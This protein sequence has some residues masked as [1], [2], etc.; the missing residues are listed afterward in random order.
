[1]HVG[2]DEAPATPPDGETAAGPD[3]GSS[4]RPRRVL[5]V[6]DDATV[7]E[8]A[9]RYL[10]R[11]GY[12]T[13]VA[14]DGPSALARAEALRPDLVVLDRMLP[15]MDGTEVLRRLR[16]RM[17][18]AVILL[19]A[20]TAEADRV[21]GLDLGA[22]DYVTKPFSPRELVAR[23]RAVLRRG[24]PAS[25]EL[26]R[27]LRA[28]PLEL[29]LP[30]R[31]LWVRGAEAPTTAREFDLLAFLVRHPGETF[32]REELL[33]RVWGWTIGDTSTVTVH[34]RH[35]REK[36]EED[37]SSPVLIKTVWSVGY[38]FDPPEDA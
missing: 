36:V 37:P 3:G 27:H 6:D 24:H 14:A 29:D 16:E 1:M 38:R 31:R 7:A 18:V 32:R 11:E 34:V 28:G 15:G 17:E 20:Q 22:D 25:P 5:V 8:V 21:A 12:A 13:A 10:Q 9:A 35:L 4:P 23:V 26:D 30:A 19:T 33:E 2:P